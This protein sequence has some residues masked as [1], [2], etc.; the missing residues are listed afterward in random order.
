MNIAGQ[1]VKIIIW[2]W[3]D[4]TGYIPCQL[5]DQ[6]IDAIA[7]ILIRIALKARGSGERDMTIKIANQH[8][9]AQGC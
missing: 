5:C 2:C 4:D 7:A 9:L 3:T 8:R 1:G 6:D